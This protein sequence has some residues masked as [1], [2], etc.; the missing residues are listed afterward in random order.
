MYERQSVYETIYN[1]IGR[2]TFV[3]FVE[4]LAALR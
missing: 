4:R 2:F 1:N 3:A